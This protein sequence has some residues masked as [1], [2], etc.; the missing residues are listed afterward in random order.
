[1]LDILAWYAVE[2][3]DPVARQDTD[4]RDCAEEEA[5]ED[6]IPSGKLL[7]QGLNSVRGGMAYVLTRVVY[8]DET[9]IETLKPALRSLA[10]DPSQ[11]VRAM[12]AETT[13]GLLRHAT[14][15][16]V[17]LFM[18]LVADSSDEMLATRYVR[19]FLRRR[20]FVDFDRLGPVI[21][22]MIES[23]LPAVQE[24]GAAQAALAALSESDAEPLVELCQAGGERLRLG[25]AKVYGANLLNARYR[26]RCELALT[27]L[28]DDENTEVRQAASKVISGL[29]DDDLLKVI[30]LV[31]RFLRT[32][33][34]AD[35]PDAAIHA[36]EFANSPPPDLVLDVCEAV[37]GGMSSRG[38]VHDRDGF[39]AHEISEQLVRAY[40]DARDDATR[41]R[42]LDLIDEAL[43]RN[44]MGTDQAL[45]E[46]DRS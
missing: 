6:E 3:P 45:S 20:V 23:D 39:R 33:A 12:A 40:A 30:P 9:S 8:H 36:I 46:H 17:E 25:L 35:A 15:L 21:Q 29:R 28:F 43:R 34:F 19:D 37:M 10:K 38:A 41:T 18:E 2:D 7:H 22:R 13:V 27:A 32:Q 16:A 44:L 11:A 42:A 1:M 24:A 5:V 31:R 26:E 4:P 14:S